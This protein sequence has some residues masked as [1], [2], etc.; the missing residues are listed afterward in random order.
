MICESILSVNCHGLEKKVVG[1]SDY[2][3]GNT[4]CIP[5]HQ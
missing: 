1:I 5:T 3:T 2:L 4:P